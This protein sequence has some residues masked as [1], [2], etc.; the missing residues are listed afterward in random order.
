M[1]NSYSKKVLIVNIKPSQIHTGR[2][3]PASLVIRWCVLVMLRNQ[4]F[5]VITMNNE[6]HS[7]ANNF[8]RYMY[9]ELCI[10]NMD[11]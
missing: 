10:V 6:N 9:I 5:Y 2:K 3:G 7:T 1:I 8:T 4:T 11:V